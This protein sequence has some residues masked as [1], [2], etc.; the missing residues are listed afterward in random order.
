MLVREFGTEAVPAAERWDLWH[1]VAVRTH[2]P[3]LLRSERRD[4]FRATM[5]LLSLPDVQISL[6]DFPQMETVRTP[7][8]IR[9]SDPEV[10]QIQCLVRGEGGAAQDGHEETFRAGDLVLVDSSRPYEARHRPAPGPV[11]AVIVT[12]PRALL[13]LPPSAM[14]RLS[15]VPV[16]LRQG[17]GG[18]LYRWLTDLAARAGEFTGAD[19]PALARTTTD[20]LASVLGRCL[21]A[22]DTLDPESRRRALH[23]RV[24]DFIERR[25]GDPSLSPAMVAAAHGIS[26]RHLHQVFAEEGQT[27]AA[28]IRHRRLERCRRD[29][30][31]LGL[32]SRSIQSVAARWGFTDPATFSRAFRRAYGMTPKDYRHSL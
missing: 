3:T 10:Y 18:V 4:D 22:E 24:R 32:R 29:L 31:D 6:L 9:R 2:L 5:R 13:P 7:R 28:W 19:A 21:E 11:S 1:E 26:V 12:L 14:R 23:L 17:L 25:L 20:L 16:P 15:A 8:L 27:P 30:A